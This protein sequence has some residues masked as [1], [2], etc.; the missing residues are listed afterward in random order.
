MSEHDEPSALMPPPPATSA[1][2]PPSVPTGYVPFGGTAAKVEPTATL[3]TASIVARLVGVAG[4][5]VAGTLFVYRAHVVDRVAAGRARPDE[6]DLPKTLT[7]LTYQLSTFAALAG[8]VLLCLW[9]SRTVTNGTIVHPN[10][11]GGGWFIPIGNFWV[12]WRH[13]RRAMGHSARSSALAWWQGLTIASAVAFVP[14]GIAA[15]IAAYRDALQR[16]VSAGIYRMQGYGLLA[17]ALA[18]AVTLVVSVRAMHDVDD[19]TS[20]RPRWLGA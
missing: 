14:I 12:P 5:A 19:A 10:T 13:L 8:T 15:G 4:S 2:A 18:S 7:T 1:W 9:S 17:S 16:E 6:L 3:R 20:G 11:A